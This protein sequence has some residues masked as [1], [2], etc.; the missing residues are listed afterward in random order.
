SM[1][2]GNPPA[3]PPQIAARPVEEPAEVPPNVLDIDVPSITSNE[4]AAP[5]ISAVKPTP[6]PESDD[7]EPKEDI[8]DLI[9]KSKGA[10]KPVT[11]EME[12]M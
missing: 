4:D 3:A 9:R 12:K 7:G 10:D 2:K 5:G 8:R 6:A 11:I 1:L